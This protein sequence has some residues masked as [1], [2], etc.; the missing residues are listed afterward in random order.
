MAFDRGDNQVGVSSVSILPIEQGGT[1]ASTAQ[2]ALSNLGLPT[3]TGNWT[4]ADASGASLTFSNVIAKYTKIGNIVTINAK[5]TYPST[6]ST[7]QA[8]ISGLPF[9]PLVSANF[10]FCNPGTTTTGAGQ[11]WVDEATTTLT[12]VSQTNASRSNANLS[13]L[14][15]YLSGTYLV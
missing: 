3:E 13:T 5:I 4:P 10:L 6:V 15:L 12:L 7:A 9:A 8:K 1:N 11:G 14:T 2:Q